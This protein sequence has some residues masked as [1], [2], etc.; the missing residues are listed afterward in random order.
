MI[1]QDGF[2]RARTRAAPVER[3]VRP[4]FVCVASRFSL[5]LTRP[6]EM[7]CRARLSRQRFSQ[8]SQQLRTVAAPG[9]P[10]HTRKRYWL[11]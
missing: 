2:M 1:Q 5:C 10:V 6:P 4:P 8:S 11:D 7:D 9:A 3:I